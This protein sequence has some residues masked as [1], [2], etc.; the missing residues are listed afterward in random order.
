M[1]GKRLTRGQIRLRGGL[2]ALAVVFAV[3]A[4]WDFDLFDRAELALLDARFALRGPLDRHPDILIVGIDEESAARDGRRVGSWTRA[5]YGRAVANLTHAGAALIVLD[6]MFAREDPDAAQDAALASALSESGRVILVSDISEKNETYPI[7][8]LRKFEA[9]EGFV[10]LIRDRDGV[11]RRIP[12]PRLAFEGES[13][14]EGDESG[15]SLMV[16]LAVEAAVHRVHP[17]GPPEVDLGEGRYHLGDVEVLTSRGG[18]LINF[19][20]GPGTF[21]TV[22]FWRTLHGE[23]RESEVAGKIVFIGSMHPLQHDH[24]PVPF[25]GTKVA[26]TVFRERTQVELGDMYGVEI[27][28]HALDTLL[29]RRPLIAPNREPQALVWVLLGALSGTV[30]IIIRLRPWAGVALVF[31]S[32]GLLGAAAQYLFVSRGLVI[33]VMPGTLILGG[34]FVA[35]IVR[36]RALDLRMKREIQ[37]LFGLYVSPQVAALMFKDP[38]LVRLGGRKAV[39]TVFFSDIRGFTSMS[40]TLPPEEVAAL[41][42]EYFTEMTSIV[43]KHGGTLDKFIGDAIMVFFGDPV[44]VADHA[45]KAV[46]MA[47][48]M[49]IAMEGLKERW[50][51]E[52]RRTFDPGMGI[53][54]GDVV[55]GNTGSA[56]RFSYTV[57]GDNVNLAARLES[58]AAAGQILISRATHDAIAEIDARFVVEALPPIKVKGK[59]QPVEIYQVLSAR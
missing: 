28:A 33:E 11:V 47:L 46:R 25:K 30:F 24:F 42:Q 20:G 41:L 59:A 34:H 13:A 50:K 39:L 45:E 18:T 55:V 52:G 44:P 38:S 48:E 21:R 17:D 31:G 19:A 5:E 4:A 29:S 16:P 35:G 53:N 1:A 6:V 32:L 49:R 51:S 8:A 40:E 57:L 56:E 12:P 14:G 27:H 10:N 43:F 15:P 54:T 26:A 58:N 23:I 3:I 22:P 9:G 7:P 2:L 36:H 37:G